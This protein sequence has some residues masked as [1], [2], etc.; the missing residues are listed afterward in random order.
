MIQDRFKVV[1]QCNRLPKNTAIL[2]SETRNRL[3]L[4][5]VSRLTALRQSR[6]L[7]GASFLLTQ[8]PQR[9]ALAA[10]VLRSLFDSGDM[11]MRFE[12][13]ADSAAQNSS[14]VAVD[15]AHA[16]QPGKKC[17]VQVFL[18]IVGRFIHRAADE[19][20]LRAYVVGV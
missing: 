13:F 18:E 8:L 12:K 14:A 19:I 11:G 15:N 17:M 10:F 2:I 3:R 5:R 4:I 1:P 20:D 6:R 7:G 16:R 9:C